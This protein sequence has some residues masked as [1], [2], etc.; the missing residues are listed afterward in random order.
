MSNMS[1]RKKNQYKNHSSAPK[2]ESI[3]DIPLGMCIVL[4]VLGGV[5]GVIFPYNCLYL[6]Q[7]IDRDDA[8]IVTGEF[9]SYEYSYSKGGAVSAVWINFADREDLYLDAYHVE[10]DEKLESLK[11]GEQLN[12]LLHPY[13]EAIWELTSEDSVILS[14][15]DA[16]SRKQFENGFFMFFLVGLCLICVI[17]GG[18]VLLTKYFRYKKRTQK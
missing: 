11:K 7:I 1:K 18:I 8:I 15:D 6:N 3:A 4:V 9:D 2:R 17:M 13:S 16:I 10:M 12:M 5:L 14:F